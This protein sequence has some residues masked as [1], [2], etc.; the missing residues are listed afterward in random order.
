MTYKIL[1]IFVSK[2]NTE[3]IQKCYKMSKAIL[4]QFNSFKMYINTKETSNHIPC[5]SLWIVI[6]IYF[7]FVYKAQ[8]DK[9]CCVMFFI[10]FN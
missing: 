7:T 8:I 1:Y 6:Q 2:C 3:T 10:F 4:F 9:N 5:Q